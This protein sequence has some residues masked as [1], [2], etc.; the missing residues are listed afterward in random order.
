[1]CSSELGFDTHQRFDRLAMD[2]AELGDK[3]V[4]LKQL[5]ELMLNCVGCHAAY[6]ID[7]PA[8]GR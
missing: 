8:N 6:R 3:M 4:A 2:A 5:S 1:M 7:T